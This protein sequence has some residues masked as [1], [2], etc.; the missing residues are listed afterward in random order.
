MHASFLVVF[1]SIGFC[2][3]AVPQ[4]V[5]AQATQGSQSTEMIENRRDSIQIRTIADIKS[6]VQDAH[7]RLRNVKIVYESRTKDHLSSKPPEIGFWLR[8]ISVK[9]IMRRF[10]RELCGRDDANLF[11]T[12]RYTSLY[13]N[14]A[15]N[16]YYPLARHYEKSIKLTKHDSTLKVRNEAFIESLSWWPPDDSSQPPE[17][18][19][20][21]FYLL[22]V[23]EKCQCK[24]ENYEECFDGV[25]CAVVIDPGRDRILIDPDTGT[26]RRR[27]LTSAKHSRPVMEYRLM[28]YSEILPK[29]FLPR[30]IERVSFSEV[31]GSKMST[32]VFVVRDYLVNQLTD[33]HFQIDPEPGTLVID[34]DTDEHSHI[35]GGFDLL[36]QVSS[37]ARLVVPF[38]SATLVKPPEGPSALFLT[39]VIATGCVSGALLRNLLLSVLRWRFGRA[40]NA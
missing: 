24:L 26:L 31:D 12:N 22:Q 5:I 10:S 1:F 18:P 34:R 38:S 40:V 11:D 37:R 21:P 16:L 20:R 14:D 39:G 33:G 29:L 36:D 2:Q 4:A 30:V 9:G 19:D 27:I 32:S 17:L 13:K 15:W 6:K 23:L 35:P 3:N 8:S 28:A 25:W 7:T